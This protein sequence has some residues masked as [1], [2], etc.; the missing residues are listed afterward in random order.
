[1]TAPN[2]WLHVRHPST[3]SAEEFELF[4]ALCRVFRAYVEASL[5][6][7][8]LLGGHEAPHYEFFEPTLSSDRKVATL[9]VGGEWTLGTRAEFENFKSYML[10]E[11]FPLPL[12][13]Q[14][15]EGITEP[16]PSSATGGTWTNWRKATHRL[17]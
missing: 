11:R 3:F 12:R 9:P 15:E 1:M 14:L 13:F 7:W 17:M 2:R 6:E 10:W 4:K 8:L 16:D 5:A